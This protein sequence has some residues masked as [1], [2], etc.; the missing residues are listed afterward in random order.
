VGPRSL[1]LLPL[2]QVAKHRCHQAHNVCCRGGWRRLLLALLQRQLLLLLLLLLLRL[3]LL[4]LT[5]LRRCLSLAVRQH[6]HR[7]CL[8]QQR[9]CIRGRE[10]GA[11]GWVQGKWQLEK[12]ASW[13]Y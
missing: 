8:A 4:Q 1:R 5:Q 13:N 3:Q 7:H 10:A 12:Q 11:S 6:Q 2:L 9:A